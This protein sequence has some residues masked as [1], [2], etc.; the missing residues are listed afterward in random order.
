MKF[1]ERA[2]MELGTVDNILVIP[3]LKFGVLRLFIFCQLARL[4]VNY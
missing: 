2:L 4:S 3:N 1:G